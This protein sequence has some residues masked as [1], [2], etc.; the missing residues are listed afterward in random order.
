[1]IA[2]ANGD[3][4]TVQ[5]LLDYNASIDIFNHLGMTALHYAASTN[6]IQSAKIFT[7][8]ILKLESLSDRMRVCNMKDKKG[9][10]VFHFAAKCGIFSGKKSL[11]II[12]FIINLIT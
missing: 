11:K 5:V 9:W 12:I 2:S 6:S 4:D 7:L 10:N 1:M 8:L 3:V